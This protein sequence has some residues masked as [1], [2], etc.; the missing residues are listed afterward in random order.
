LLIWHTFPE[1][2]NPKGSAIPI[3]YRDILKAGGK[4]DL[5]IAAIEEEMEHLALTDRLL[6]AK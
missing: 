4:T 5:E 3:D 6:S 1:W 2:Q